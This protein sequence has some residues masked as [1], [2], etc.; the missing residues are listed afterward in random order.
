MGIMTGCAGNGVVSKGKID[1]SPGDLTV[2]WT[3]HFFRYPDKMIAAG[4]MVMLFP[5]VTTDAE[6]S[7]FTLE[8]DLR[9]PLSLL[10]VGRGLMTP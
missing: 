5:S 7:W 3:P 4:G 8:R 6:L 10:S 2:E 9:G 1:F